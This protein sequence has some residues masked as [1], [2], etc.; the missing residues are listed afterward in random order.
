MW[1]QSL[2]SKLQVPLLETPITWCDNQ[3]AT[4]ITANPVYHART[5]HIEIDLH[6]VRDQVINKK[7]QVC[8]V[9]SSDQVADCFTKPLSHSRFHFLI[10]KLG[11][12]KS[13]TLLR[14]AVEA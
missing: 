5:K 11:V 6:F 8:Y 4:A 9:P 3:S 13:P 12:Q 10:S 2:L 7:L 14:G 1:I